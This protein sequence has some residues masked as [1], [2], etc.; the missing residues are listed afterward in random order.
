MFKTLL[1]VLLAL[2]CAFTAYLFWQAG[3]SADQP[4]PDPTM[5]ELK[6]CP[7]KPNCVST[8]ATQADKKRDPIAYTG[9]RDEAKT[10]LLRLLDDTPRTIRVSAEGNYVHYTFK[11]WP[12]PFTD[13][14]EFLFDDAAKVIHYRSASRVGHSDLG[15]NSKRMAKLV[16]AYAAD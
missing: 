14:V 7:D 11:T 10:K 4:N 2:A 12:I 3:N 13:D 16:D 1:L 5:T 8:Q 15:V 9:S 6:P